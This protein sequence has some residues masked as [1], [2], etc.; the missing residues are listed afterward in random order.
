MNVFFSGVLL[1]CSLLLLIFSPEKLLDSLLT[2]G[3]EGLTFSLKLF[4]VYAVWLS[5]LDL[6]KKLGIDRFLGKILSKVTKKVFP[7]ENDLCYDA[8]SVNLSANMLGMGG[9]G[10]PAGIK[11][12]E[13]MQ[14][15]KN[16]IMLIVINSSSVQLIPTTIIAMRSSYG[17]VTDIILPSLIATFVSTFS[18][19]LAVKFL[20]K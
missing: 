15:K 4:A 18:G 11:A 20:V 3:S 8:L 10:T 5:I 2:G 14:S 6:W 17:S 19:F 9:A 1:V 13:N 7:D 16:R 12:A